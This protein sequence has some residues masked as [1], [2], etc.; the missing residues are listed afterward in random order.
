[1]RLVEDTG[2]D[3]LDAGPLATS[4]QQQPGTPAYCTELTTAELAAA[5]QAAD[6]SR[7]ADNRDRLIKKF[8]ETGKMPDHDEAVALN[9]KV[10][11]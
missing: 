8:S 1:M 2:F 5:L 3:A 11:A 6:Q 9:R 7:A 4:W 10:T